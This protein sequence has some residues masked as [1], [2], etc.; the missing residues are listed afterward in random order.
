MCS[1]FSNYS[2]R[3][4]QHNLGHLYDKSKTHRMFALIMNG[5]LMCAPKFMRTMAMGSI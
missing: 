2:R 3:D 4:S 1:R 5:I